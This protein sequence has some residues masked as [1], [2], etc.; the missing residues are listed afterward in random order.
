MIRRPPR[1]T[2]F[3]YTTLFRSSLAGGRE[4]A[5]PFLSEMVP[6]ELDEEDPVAVRLLDRSPGGVRLQLSGRRPE[7]VDP[8]PNLVVLVS[9]DVDEGAVPSDRLLERRKERFVLRR[10]D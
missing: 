1:S 10:E 7:L 9:D 6:E 8:P 2:L 5:H 3:P 4:Q